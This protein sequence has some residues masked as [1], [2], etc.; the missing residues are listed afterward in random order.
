[1]LHLVDMSLESPPLYGSSLVLSL[2]FKTLTFLKSSGQSFS[3][4]FLSLSLLN[5][6]S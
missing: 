5:T 6:F 2:S 3:R 1:M 4:M